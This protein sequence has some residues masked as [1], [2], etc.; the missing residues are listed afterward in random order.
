MA[1]KFIAMGEP[2]IGAERAKQIIDF[3]AALDDAP[4]VAAL[5]NLV[6]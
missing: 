6:A 1:E 3:V 2:V 5:M 4:S